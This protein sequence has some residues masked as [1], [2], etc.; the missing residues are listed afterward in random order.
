MRRTLTSIHYTAV[1]AQNTQR[2]PCHCDFGITG[3]VMRR[4]VLVDRWMT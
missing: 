4:N 1:S 3:I 2:G